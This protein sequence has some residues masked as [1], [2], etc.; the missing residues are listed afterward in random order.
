MLNRG[1]VKKDFRVIWWFLKP[2]RFQT[3][4][5][6]LSL[7]IVAIFE[8]MSIGAFYPFIKSIISGSGE[9]SVGGGKV[10]EYL[11]SMVRFIPVK[12]KIIAASIF[13]LILTVTSSIF[14]FF[15]ESFSVWYR[16]KLYAV[17]LNNVYKK[18]GNNKYG[19]F[20][21]KKQGDLL[22]IGMSAAQSVGEMLLYFPRIGIEVF[23]IGAITIL[24]F[25]VSPKITLL[26]LVVILLFGLSIRH[27]SIKVIYPIAVGLQNAQSE[28][29][30]VFS[31]S[32]AGIRQIKSFDTFG[33]WFQ[34]FKMQTNRS[35]MLST[36]VQF[37][38]MAHHTW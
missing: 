21:D 35:R 13:L 8:T 26:I 38:G 9:L 32:I 5:I 20:L 23:R 34:R 24:L 4:L 6:F 29:T 27:L 19:F 30:A 14:G 15:A 3:F 33:Y 31:E 22:Y 36:K 28:I 1:K 17:F 2:Y 10:L 12:E 25:T 11:S 18:F 16:Y 7:F 37:M